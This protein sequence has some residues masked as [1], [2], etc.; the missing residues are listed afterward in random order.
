[1]LTLWNFS[2]VCLNSPWNER[3]LAT[4]EPGH[5]V[6]AIFVGVAR[7]GEHFMARTGSQ[8]LIGHTADLPDPRPKSGERFQLDPQQR[9]TTDDHASRETVDTL[10]ADREKTEDQ[11][12]RFSRWTGKRLGSR[13]QSPDAG[14]RPPSGGGRSRRR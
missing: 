10:S 6:E 14:R 9:T 7:S 5:Q 8:I 1:L 3:Y 11:E 12:A 13:S 2:D 4:V